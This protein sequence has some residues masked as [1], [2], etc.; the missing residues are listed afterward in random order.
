MSRTWYCCLIVVGTCMCRCLVL[1]LVNVVSTF[2]MFADC[3]HGC[4]NCLWSS[5]YRICA[6]V[7]RTLC[8]SS[9]TGVGA[10]SSLT[11]W[12][13]WVLGRAGESSRLLS[14][15]DS[16][17]LIIGVLVWLLVSNGIKSS[18]SRCASEVSLRFGGLDFDL[19]PVGLPFTMRLA[20]CWW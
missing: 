16:V 13:C 19:L 20:A 1:F 17:L 4:G 15:V 5:S 11:F 12:C 9:S 3:C 7:A 2:L 6:V 10:F 14:I 18:D 8:T